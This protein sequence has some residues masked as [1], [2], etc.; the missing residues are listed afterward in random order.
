MQALA[1]HQGSW[2]GTNGFRLMPTDE[3]FEAP[4]TVEIS[5]AAGGHLT[6]VGYTWV[7]AD[8][9][10]QDGLLTIGAAEQEGEKEGKAVAL[11]GDSWH[12]KPN[13]TTLTGS[14]A[15]GVLTLSCLYAGDWEWII[16]LDTT[17]PDELLLRMDNVVPPSAGDH[18]TTYW[19]MKLTAQPRT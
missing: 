7:H 11:W 16:T 1:K 9:G 15:D 6:V 4:A 5:S 8:D 3:P 2:T 19:A 14:L 10:P 17:S 18:A 12:Q 13:P